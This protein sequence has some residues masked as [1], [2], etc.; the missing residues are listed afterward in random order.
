M[1]PSYS[2][3]GVLEVPDFFFIIFS[4][5]LTKK[6]YAPSEVFP[7]Q[8]GPNWSIRQ[9]ETTVP[10][11]QFSPFPFQIFLFISF[12]PYALFLGFSLPLFSLFPFSLPIFL[13]Y[14]LHSLSLPNSM[15][16]LITFPYFPS[17]HFPLFFSY[18]FPF[19]PFSIWA[20]S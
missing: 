8:I 9:T 7:H 11:V 6:K 3:F 16:T 14:L 15:F 1:Y 13:V 12:S 4:V 17:S 19:L 2:Y 18:P 10:P 20:L 5:A